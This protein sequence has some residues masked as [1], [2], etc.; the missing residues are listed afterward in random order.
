MHKT[1]RNSSWPGCSLKLIP[2]RRVL[3]ENNVEILRVRCSGITLRQH[4]CAPKSSFY[5]YRC[6]RGFVFNNNQ[7]MFTSLCNTEGIWER[8]ERCIP[9]HQTTT[10]RVE[11][12][13]TDNVDSESCTLH[14]IPNQSRLRTQ[15]LVLLDVHC[16][17]IKTLSDRCISKESYVKYSCEKGYKFESNQDIFI[18]NCH[19]G[20]WPNAPRCVLDKPLG[21]PNTCSID[22]IPNRV[23]LRERRLV[24]NNIRCISNPSTPRKCISKRSVVEYRCQTGYIFE[25]RRE[26]FLSMCED[27]GL[28]ELIPRCIKNSD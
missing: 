28:W 9:E 26:S 16:S 3:Q 20:S 18:A 11:L 14:A 22:S 8:L 13:T 5:S 21:S 7:R 1:T 24:L 6:A 25:N 19:D 15:H 4:R 23:A 2:T 17:R 10:T 27:D 12:T